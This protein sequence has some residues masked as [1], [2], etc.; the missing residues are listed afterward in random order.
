MTTVKI[1]L[2]RPTP[3]G[4]VPATGYVECIPTLRHTT[5]PDTAIVLPARFSVHL[6]EPLLA[7][8]GETVLQAA[9]DGVAW[10]E[11][12]PTDVGE[13]ADLWAWRFTEKTTNGQ[14]RYCAVPTAVGILDYADL[15]DVDPETFPPAIPAVPVWTLAIA[16]AVASLQAADTALHATIS[17]E[18]A[19]AITNAV[20][21]LVGGAP[22]ALDTLNELAAALGD[23]A[24]FAANLTNALAS[25]AD[26]VGGTIPDAQLPANLAR[27]TEVAAAVAALVDAAPGTLDTLNELAAAL[28]D[29]PNFAA[30]ITTALAA[31]AATADVSALVAAELAGYQPGLEVGYAERTTSATS[32]Q[33][34]PN[35]TGTISGLS[36]T[37]VGTGRPVDIR[38]G[39]SLSWNS[40]ANKNVFASLM[41]NGGA[42]GAAAADSSPATNTGP[43]LEFTRRMVLTNGVSYTFTVA[44]Y[45]EAGGGTVTAFANSTYPMSL[46]V[47]NR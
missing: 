36:V 39:A 27:D 29:D 16:A 9:E 35:A 19:T 45:T 30:T 17:A 20:N 40:V 21:G 44:L 12:E 26:L 18:T 8:D 7:G 34:A 5:D 47:T 28:G 43:R 6:G 23:D 2:L 3:A 25:K 15:E 10:A 22:G 11:L 32:A 1:T 38:F 4:N 42:T 33:T 13:Y 14:R 41:V 46:S 37:V 24:D 31:K